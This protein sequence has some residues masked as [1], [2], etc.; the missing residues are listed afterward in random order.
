MKT[1]RGKVSNKRTKRGRVNGKKIRGSETGG[2]RIGEARKI[3]GTSSS[4]I[5]LV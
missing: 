5:V 3:E 2:R 4:F 1:G